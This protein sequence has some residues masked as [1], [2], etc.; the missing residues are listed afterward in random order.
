MVMWYNSVMGRMAMREGWQEKLNKR[1]TRMQGDLHML[2]RLWPLDKL[3]LD[4]RNQN[5]I[6]SPKQ[7][8]EAITYQ[9]C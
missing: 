6:Q 8:F 4:T 9:P 7:G 3:A 2:Y 5:Q 1:S